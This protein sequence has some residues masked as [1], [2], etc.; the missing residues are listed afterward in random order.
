MCDSLLAGSQ[1]F[2]RCFDLHVHCSYIPIVL[3]CNFFSLFLP[4]FFSG[5]L[6]ERQGLTYSQWSQMIPS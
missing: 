6:C 3:L 1:C 4:A 5:V 2:M